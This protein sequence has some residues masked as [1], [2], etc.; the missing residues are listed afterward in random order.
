MN[1]II[2]II[3]ILSI[4][5]LMMMK[6]QWQVR[7]APESLTVLIIAVSVEIVFGIF[8]KEKPPI[9]DK[10]LWYANTPKDYLWSIGIGIICLFSAVLGLLLNLLGDSWGR[11]IGVPVGYISAIITGLLITRA[12]IFFVFS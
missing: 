3:I 4:Y 6:F 8:L 12:T 10:G 11:T 1:S 7:N 2:F 5:V 9:V